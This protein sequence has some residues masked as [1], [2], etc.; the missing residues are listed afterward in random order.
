[1]V[2]ESQ[3]S[4]AYRCITPLAMFALIDAAEEALATEQK[5]RAQSSQV[6]GLLH[7]TAAAH[8]RST[9]SQSMSTTFWI[10]ITAN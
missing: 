10:V 7:E 6:V 8:G 2:E 5:H 1:M 3:A 9:R 4:L